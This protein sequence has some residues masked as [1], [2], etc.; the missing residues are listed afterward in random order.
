MSGRRH[1]YEEI[2][3]KA[4]LYAFETISTLVVIGLLLDFAIKELQPVI[5]SLWHLLHA[6]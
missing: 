6:P 2:L 3:L 4:K 1:S 5:H